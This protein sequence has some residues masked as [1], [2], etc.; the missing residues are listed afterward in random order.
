TLFRIASISKTFT[1]LLGLQLVD[2]GRLD[3]DTP[4]NDYLP[5]ALKLPDEGWPTVLVRHLFT[6]TAGF[7]DSAMGHLFVDR[8][9]RVLTTTEYLQRH[10][11]KR[12]RA[13]GTF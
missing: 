8:A 13:P 3:L 12:V 2:D 10:R 9:E 5:D 11:P 1:Y 4:V 6:H 7:E